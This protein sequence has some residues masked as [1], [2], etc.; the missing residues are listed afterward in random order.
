MIKL[1]AQALLFALGI[2]IGFI[3]GFAISKKVSPES[4]PLCISEDCHQKR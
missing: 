3:G 2:L 4:Y 1:I